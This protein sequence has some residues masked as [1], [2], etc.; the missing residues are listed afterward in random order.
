MPVLTV[1]IPTRGLAA[2]TLALSLL[3]CSAPAPRPALCNPAYAEARF[4]GR[5]LQVLPLRDVHVLNHGDL[6]DDFRDSG[7][8]A[9]AAPQVMFGGLMRQALE[10][11]A[12]HA[13]SSAIPMLHQDSGAFRD[14]VL[15][16]P[17]SGAQLRTAF[18]FPRREALETEGITPDLGLQ[19]DHL[20][21]R[22]DKEAAGGPL[23][24]AKP[25]I[26]SPPGSPSA[27][28][29]VPRGNAQSLQAEGVYILWDYRADALVACGHFT[30]YAPLYF[31]MR[32]STWEE[33]FNAIVREIAEGTPLKGDKIANF[34]SRPRNEPARH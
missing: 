30:V 25:A 32:K 18:S 7:A 3:A 22:R 20:W 6:E 8:A 31:G 13:V 17:S 27:L 14:T 23:W 34:S 28:R 16:I 4:E 11:F 1:E 10:R 29:M 9:L 12:D 5:T 15:T 24:V 26:G 2:G 19:L 21:F 33:A